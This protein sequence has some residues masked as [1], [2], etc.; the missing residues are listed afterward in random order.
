MT[1]PEPGRFTLRT[2]AFIG[3][4]PPGAACASPHSS[5]YPG[6]HTIKQ[7]QSHQRPSGFSSHASATSRSSPGVSL[8]DA[9]RPTPDAPVRLANTPAKCGSG[10]RGRSRVHDSFCRRRPACSRR[11]TGAVRSR[12]SRSSQHRARPRQRSSAPRPDTS[13]ERRNADTRP[14]SPDRVVRGR[15]RAPICEPWPN[16]RRMHSQACHSTP[17]VGL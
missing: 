4:P 13:A 15:Q 1:P 11:P 12:S 8:S 16:A 3:V 9:R 17:W 2:I 5:P 14:C 6:T 7:G 10:S